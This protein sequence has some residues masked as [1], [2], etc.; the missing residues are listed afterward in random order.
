VWVYARG[1]CVRGKRGHVSH[2]GSWDATCRGPRPRAGS[3]AL[4]AGAASGPGRP[5]RG[6]GRLRRGQGR[7]DHAGAGAGAAARGR[8]R[9][10]APPRAGEREGGAQGREVERER[11]EKGRGGELTSGSKFR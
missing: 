11:E 10:R 5:R 1:E 3:C 2:A 7:A 9:G 8:G 6:P 4:G